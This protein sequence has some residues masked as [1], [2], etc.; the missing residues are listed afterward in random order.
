MPQSKAT[1]SE[2]TASDITNELSLSTEA[3]VDAGSQSLEKN[4]ESPARLWPPPLYQAYCLDH[5]LMECS[6]YHDEEN[7][8]FRIMADQLRILTQMTKKPSKWSAAP[9]RVQ[10]SRRAREKRANPEAE[11]KTKTIQSQSVSQ[12]D[13]E[14]KS[15]EPD[16]AE[17]D[18]GLKVL[19]ERLDLHI[20]WL[21]YK[22]QLY[23][24][25]RETSDHLNAKN[26]GEGVR[27]PTHTDCAFAGALALEC[28]YCGLRDTILDE[29]ALTPRKL[30]PPAPMHLIEAEDILPDQVGQFAGITFAVDI[31]G[32][33]EKLVL[34]KLV[35]LQ[36]ICKDEL[37][38]TGTGSPDGVGDTKTES[39]PASSARSTKRVRAKET[40]TANKSETVSTRKRRKVT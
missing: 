17:A 4:D 40:D 3:E 28:R 8:K 35:G 25:V 2:G 16:P 20:P 24:R 6:I 11:T 23:T 27:T 34:L 22:E 33:E 21:D 12:E 10:P 26:E 18:K 39:E 15:V 38:R 7:R 14:E 32:V 36:D 9:T 19:H 1:K 30:A 31:C 5:F 37:E 13:E 29:G